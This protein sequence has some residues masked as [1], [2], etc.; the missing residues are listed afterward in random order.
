MNI[1]LILGVLLWLAFCLF[2][3]IV[4]YDHYVH[5]I[6]MLSSLSNRIQ[7]VFF[8]SCIGQMVFIVVVA[9]ALFILYTIIFDNS[10][11]KD[12]SNIYSIS[13]LNNINNFILFSHKLGLLLLELHNSLI[14]FGQVVVHSF[15]AIVTI[16]IFNLLITK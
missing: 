1:F 13:S 12:S 14:K 16:T 4:L 15:F 2:L 5:K 6:P 7:Q 8:S 3:F 9:F 11:Y 10:L